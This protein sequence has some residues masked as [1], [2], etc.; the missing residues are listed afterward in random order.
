MSARRAALALTLG[1]LGWSAVARANGRFPFAQQVVIGP[2][3]R[4]DVVVLRTT[5]GL[6]VSRDGGASFRWVCEDSMFFPYVPGLMV[7]PAV[8]VTSEGRVAL[9]F[10]SGVHSFTDGC[11]VRRHAPTADH[12]VIDLAA[13]PAGDTLYGVEST[14]GSPSYVLRGGAALDLARVGS[15]LPGLRFAT[16]EVAASE[17]RRIYLSAVEERSREPRLLRSDDAGETVRAL[18]VP[19]STLGDGA[20]VSG[21]DPTDADVLYV[22]AVVGF[23]S[24][25]LRSSDGG[26]SFRRV[27]ATRDAMLGF[28]ISDD[29]RTVWYGSQAEGV[30]RSS[31]RGQSFERVNALPT[32]CLRQ[33]AGVL[34]ACTDWISQRWA[35]G[36]SM[37]G[38]ASFTAVLRFGD[39]AGPPE[40]ASP[41]EGAMICGERWPTQRAA[42][43][44]PGPPPD[45]GSRLDVPL[46]DVASPGDVAPADDGPVPQ[47]VPPVFD[48]GARD[49][50]AVPPP[51][52]SASCDCRATPRAASRA[53]WLGLALGLALASR[54]RFQL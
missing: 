2:G 32:L 31:D 36:R 13:T 11:Q 35:L 5:F 22:R 42:L 33:H 8:E 44:D 1:L 45:A 53:P 48:A 9:S 12:D 34:W 52:P 18:M 28:A 4:S 30:F 10:E 27:A 46:A 43:E 47:D 25:L 38:G 6:L 29:G 19:G 3:S 16:V 37:D 41:D 51:A 15:P 26:A 40:C 14:A 24:D 17:P 23:G 39:V 7:D 20:Y 21:V 50:A 49:S 54:R